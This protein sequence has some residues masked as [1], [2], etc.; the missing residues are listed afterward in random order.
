MKSKKALQLFNSEQSELTV[1][2]TSDS[3]LLYETLKTILHRTL[4][5]NVFTYLEGRIKFDQIANPE[6]VTTSDPKIDNSRMTIY[7][8]VDASL[9]ELTKNVLFIKFECR[10]RNK[11][12]RQSDFASLEATCKM[13]ELLCGSGN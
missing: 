11:L 9:T 1:N 3:N 12:Y 6:V 2:I 5:Y 8:K 4:Q 13:E 7:F 10:Y